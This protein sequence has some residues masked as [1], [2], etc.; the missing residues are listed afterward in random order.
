[1]TSNSAPSPFVASA[2]SEENPS[3][4]CACKAFDG[5]T[6]YWVSAGGGGVGWLKL[7]IGSGN[8]KI[9]KSYGVKVN[10]I[11][12]PNRAPKNWTM[13]GS[14]DNSTWA[15]L[16]TVTNQTSW[17]SGELRTFVCDI[18]ITAY[19]YF[20]INITANNGDANIEI[21][22]LYLF[23]ALPVLTSFN[24]MDVDSRC[25]AFWKMASG[26]LTTDTKS[27]NTLT[28]YNTPISGTDICGVPSVRLNGSNQY[29]VI[30]D[31]S[32]AAGFPFKNGDTGKKITV[33]VKFRALTTGEFC[34]V[35]KSYFGT[36]DSFGVS[37]NPDYF[38]DWSGGYYNTGIGL[39]AIINGYDYQLIYV[40]DG[41]AKTCQIYLYSYTLQIFYTATLITMGSALAGSTLD[42][43]L[44]YDS[45][46][47]DYANVE[48]AEV[49]V[50]NDLLSG[51]D[52]IDICRGVFLSTTPP[53]D[54]RSL[55]TCDQTPVVPPSDARSLTICTTITAW[56]PS[57]TRSLS[58]CETIP[59]PLGL[60]Q[61][62]TTCEV[63]KPPPDDVRSL[64]VSESILI[65]PPDDCRSITYCPIAAGGE[66]DA[67]RSV[68]LVPALPLPLGEGT[69]M[70]F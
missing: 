41:A 11:P 6:N 29:L 15:T 49:A 69:F 17:G 47:G 67:A 3:A 5:G 44:G 52:I 9:L 40:I 64:T 46:R 53:A 7:D 32:L 8:T 13:E 62:L 1:M 42:F 28:A 59:P 38:I 45:G 54:S 58:T 25:V 20:R 30:A 23:D 48:L 27:T 35:G 50:F 19:R 22:E 31:A 10:I 18:A 56:P 63:I 14:N 68:S 70:I 16:H 51:Q 12:E 61:S 43:R 55:T 65:P 37:F 57:D 60:C 34:T 39:P 4:S 36:N 2:S 21:C 26:A 66:P 33:A 24:A